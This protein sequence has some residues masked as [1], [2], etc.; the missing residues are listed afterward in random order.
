[1]MGCEQNVD[2]V[3]VEDLVQVLAQVLDV[4]LGR[5]WQSLDEEHGVLESDWVWH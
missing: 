5:D 4:H 3:G 1:M 2:V